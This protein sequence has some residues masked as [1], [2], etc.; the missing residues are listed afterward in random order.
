MQDTLSSHNPF[1]RSL[2]FIPIN[3]LR[4]GV[5]IGRSNSTNSLF[6]SNTLSSPNGSLIFYCVGVSIQMSITPA[7]TPSRD[8]YCETF[9][10]RV[11]PLGST[12]QNSPG[13]IRRPGKNEV[14][15]FIRGLEAVYS[16]S[17]LA[18]EIAVMA[19]AYVDRFVAATGIH[20]NPW[21][22]RRIVFAAFLLAHKIW[23]E[24]SVWNA[25]YINVFPDMEVEDINRLEM[26][27]LLA[28]DYNVSLKASTYA[29]YYFALHSIAGSHSKFDKKPLDKQTAKRMEERSRGIPIQILKKRARSFQLSSAIQSSEH[30]LS[31]EQLRSISL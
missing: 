22:W 6:I 29:S 3:K 28:V 25:D 20:L 19:V 1:S 24:K 12:I 17:V 16:G 23:E 26:G 27:F 21:S 2:P 11:Y 15:N 13:W 7:V 31:V 14:V 10:E 4:S 8:P 30:L 9:D 5:K 18:P